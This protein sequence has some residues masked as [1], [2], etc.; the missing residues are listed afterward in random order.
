MKSYSILLFS[1]LAMMA[2]SD[3]AVE[4]ESKEKAPPTACECVDHYKTKD[5]AIKAQCD[6][7]RKDEAYDKSFKKCLGAS[8]LGKSPDQVEFVEE[9]EMK[10]SMPE[11]G[12]FEMDSKRSTI[13]WVGK[14]IGKS[15][16]GEISLKSGYLSFENEQLLDAEIIIDMASL[17]NRDLKDD[18]ERNK[19]EA[20]LKSDDFFGVANHPEARFKMKSTTINESSTDLAG[21][22]TIKGKTHD[23]T[24]RNVIFAKSGRKEVVLGGALVFDRTDYDV[25]FGSRKFFDDLGDAVIRDEVTINFKV[26]AKK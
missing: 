22:L 19:L 3:Q 12:R 2:C 25:R 5:A 24:I 21:E 17:V 8:I 14:K 9:G 18:E 11:E 10:L 13:T 23:A 4:A 16:R 20:H 15:H 26:R 7:L 6:E 1:A